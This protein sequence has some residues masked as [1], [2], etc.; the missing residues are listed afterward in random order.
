M[1][2]ANQ[3]NIGSMLSGS[4]VI[5]HVANTYTK[6]QI[7]LA[8][9][10]RHTTFCVLAKLQGKLLV[11]DRHCSAF[12]PRT[13]SYH[14][15]SNLMAKFFYRCIIQLVSAKASRLDKKADFR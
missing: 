5:P 6:A 12:G 13:Q 3:W 4:Q 1:S 14:L 2:A 8:L 11:S 15:R 7:R 10:V 9:E